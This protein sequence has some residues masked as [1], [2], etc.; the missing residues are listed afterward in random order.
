MKLYKKHKIP[1][2]TQAAVLTNAGEKLSVEQH[3]IVMPRKGEVLIKMAATPINPSDLSTLRGNYPHKKTYPFVPGLEGCGQVV[4]CG[5]GFM[6]NFLLG[7][8]VACSPKE[9]GDGCWSEYMLTSA[10]NCIPVNKS[11]T[12]KQAASLVVNPLTA[13]GL[14]EKVKNCGSTAF[15]NTAAAGAL[16][17]MLI[18]LAKTEN[19][20]PI[21]I[22]RRAA[23]VEE[24]KAMGA[25]HV[26]NSNDDDFK[27][28]LKAVYEKLNAK[29][30]LDCLSGELSTQLSELAPENSETVLYAALS[31]ER[32][33]LNPFNLV[34]QGKV[35]SGFHLG[36][37]LKGKSMFQLLQISKRVQKNIKNGI[38]G[39]KVNKTYGLDK[40]NEAVN[41]YENNMTAG[42]NLIEFPQ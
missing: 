30:I 34:G 36:F 10:S 20:T 33:N 41:V 28:Q 15:V 32:L 3:E 18:R 4:A 26:L 27:N 9:T 40:I 7:K 17:K 29:I 21:N 38:L 16:G 1:K 25:Q 12:N 14:I 11:L 22:V 6:P 42:K 13:M 5:E 8:R 23:Q 35:V 2:Q 31:Q 24:L 39:S 19:L 37:W